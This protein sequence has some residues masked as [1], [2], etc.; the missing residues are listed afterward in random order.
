MSLLQD[1]RLAIRL[2]IRGRWVTAVAAGALALGI[3]STTAVFSLL[4]AVIL[5]GVPF[6]NPEQVVALGT[7]D[8]RN[9]NLGVSYQDFLDWRQQATTFSDMVLMGQPPFNISDADI[10]PDRYAG[11]FVSAQM[12]RM[13]GVSPLIGRAFVADDD[14]DGASAVAVIGYQMWQSRYGGS[15]SVIGRSIRINS[16]PVTVIGVMPPGMQ[17]PPNTDV[18]MPLS[19]ATVTRTQTRDARIYQVI[20]RMRDGVSVAQAQS[21]LGSI[22]S[23]LAKDFPKTNSDVTPTVQ[24]FNERTVGSQLRVIFWS[25]MGAV[26][27]VL[28]IACA[29]VANLL[30]ARAADRAKEVG[31]RISLG[32]SR[33]RIV[34]QLLVESVLLAFL[35]GAVGIPLAYLGVD[36]FDGATTNVGKPY[37]MEFVIDGRVLGVFV[38]VCGA[39]G[40]LFGLAPALHVT[41]TSLNEVLKEGGRQGSGGVRARRWTSGLLVAQVALTLVLLG[42]AGVMMR[43]FL[44]LYRLDLGIDTSRLLTMQ[45]NVNFRKYATPEQRTTF[46]RQLDERLAAIQGVDNVTTASAWPMGG[47]GVQQLSVDGRTD[48][49]TRLPLVTII[50]AG[51]RYFETIGL[52]L[53][54]GRGFEAGD[55]A[56]GRT[57]AIVNQRL[58]EMHFGGAD[59]IGRQIRLTPE[60]SAG[61]T[62][63]P[64]L[65]IVGVAANVRQRNVQDSNGD[66]DPI[67]YLPFL[68]GTDLATNVALIASTG[69]AAATVVPQIREAVYALDPDMPV[70]NVRSMDEVLAQNRWPF[71][72]FGTM[73][74]IFAF[75]ALVL[76]AVG[77]YAVMAYSVTQRTQ[78][79]G[80]RLVL[81]AAQGEVVWLFLRKALVLVAIGLVI[82]LAG[83]FGV[84]RL[85]QSVVVGGGQDAW[86]LVAIAVLMIT[87]AFTACAW[88]ARRAAR[89]DPASALRYE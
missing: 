31:V 74:T 4:D 42:G 47:G 38:A 78:E 59:P 6:P 55:N 9:R 87:V 83:A 63:L 80:V 26:V 75:I 65:T 25:L 88:P 40:I 73:F 24:V 17:F 18:W 71:R 5:K 30:L 44:T 12:F 43:S 27:F 82:G 89:L 77:L 54:R 28:L 76:A 79:V 23:R 85:L 34:R 68:A 61:G 52:P 57:T 33:W 49:A 7:R 60:I 70:F 56:P 35:A 13:I 15:P 39:T 19:Q 3:A 41:R 36:L 22:A 8:V 29:N 69:A 20:A 21:D 16:L 32:A 62:T 58:V 81:G 48:P 2:L 51:A 50:S 84:S 72:T 10:A 1:L 46:M 53:V 45:V 86:T 14:R 67:V 11:A 37:W 64:P 66:T